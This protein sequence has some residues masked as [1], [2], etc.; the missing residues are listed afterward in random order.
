M[1][2]VNTPPPKPLQTY[3]VPT[4]FMLTRRGLIPSYF[5][6]LFLQLQVKQKRLEEIDGG[7]FWMIS[8]PIAAARIMANWINGLNN[9][10]IDSEQSA[11]HITA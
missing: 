1:S 10:Q 3:S 2:L 4:M 6:N 11:T 9:Q 5:K 7:V 8:N